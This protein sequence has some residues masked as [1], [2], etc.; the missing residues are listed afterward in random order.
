[1]MQIKII[2][3]RGRSPCLIMELVLVLDFGLPCIF[4]GKKMSIE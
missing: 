3:K 1:M 4:M 2:A